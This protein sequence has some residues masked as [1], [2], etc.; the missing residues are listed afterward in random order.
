LVDGLRRRWPGELTVEVAPD[1]NDPHE[2]RLVKLDASK[3]RARLGWTPRW[4]LER[5]IEAIVDWYDPYR[6]GRDLRAV[7]LEQIEAFGQ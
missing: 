4:S 3:A 1:S 5:A 7:S 2:A 6:G